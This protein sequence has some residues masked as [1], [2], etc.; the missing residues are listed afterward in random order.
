MQRVLAQVGTLMLSFGLLILATGTFNTFIGVR[1]GIEGFS[2]TIIGAMM[3]AFYVGT[4]VG[5]FLCGGII[6]RVGHI[7]AFTAFAA[8]SAVTVLLHPFLFDPW[9]WV[10][11]RAI[12]GFA[13]AG[14][15]ICTE[16]WINDRV[17]AETRGTVLALHAMV[18]S[19]GF[20]AGQI[21]LNAGDPAGADLFMIAAMLFALGVIPIALTRASSPSIVESHAFGLGELYRAAPSAVVACAAGGLSISSLFG[22]GPVF[23]QALGLSVGQISSLM[24]ALIL[25]GL[26]LQFPIGWLSDRYDRRAVIAGV[27]VSAAVIAA[28]LGAFIQESA[29][30]A[31]L[32]WDRHA[33]PL[34]V[35]AFAFGGVVA[36]LYPLGIAYANDYLS[37]EQ[38]VQAAGGLVLAYGIGAVGGPVMAAVAI[39]ALGPAGLFAYNAAIGIGLLVFIGYRMRRRSWAGIREKEA[40]HLVPEATGTPT[41]VEYDPRWD[42]AETDESADA[43]AAADV[44]ST[45]S[46]EYWDEPWRRE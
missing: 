11:L 33:I 14:L 31:G 32:D 46:D 3:S 21:M 24:T 26:F 8:L 13:S 18:A 7:R 29:T 12:L 1:S 2:T 40:F 41:G 5:A 9:T 37:P 16:S 42:T 20:G 35:M 43:R 39:D 44:D 10:V 45:Q 25:S 23:G 27:A 38:R 4:I 19:L 36:T 6:N 34:L 15:Y 28:G 22:V 30:P 17:T